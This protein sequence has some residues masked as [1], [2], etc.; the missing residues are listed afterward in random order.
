MCYI[1]NNKYEFEEFLIY[2]FLNVFLISFVFYL[3]VRL[4]VISDV[5]FLYD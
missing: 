5:I 1:F 4:Y 3:S 2:N